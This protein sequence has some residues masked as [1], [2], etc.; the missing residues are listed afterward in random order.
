M[1]K[2]LK[3]FLNYFLKIC[4][5]CVSDITWAKETTLK[6]AII[7]LVSSLAGFVKVRYLIDKAIIDNIVFR[8]HYRVTSAILF[9]CCIIVTANNLIGKTMPILEEWHNFSFWKWIESLKF[10]FVPV[11]VIQSVALMMELCL[12]MWSTHTVGSHT[13][14]LCL[15]S[16]ASQRDHMWLTLAWE[17]MLTMRMPHVITP[18]TSGFHSCSSSRSVSQNIDKSCDQCWA[19]FFKMCFHFQGILFY[20]PHWIW[21]NWEEGKVRMISDGMRG[22]MIGPKENRRDKVNRLVQYIMDTLHMHN[23]YAAGYFLCEALNFA[24]VVCMKY[25]EKV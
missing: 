17:T 18:T 10:C 21:K 1:R 6:M 12:D 11:K 7:G 16:K 2:N 3:S 25:Y 23:F 9:L 20:V 4:L 24:N 13:L 14:L 5:L 15:I 19:L 22:A 8:C